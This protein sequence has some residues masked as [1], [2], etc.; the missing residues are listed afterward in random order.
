MTVGLHIVLAMIRGALSGNQGGVFRRGVPV[1]KDQLTST[2]TTG[3]NVATKETVSQITSRLDTAQREHTLQR[4]VV[5]TPVEG[6]VGNIVT[7]PPTAK[8][9]KLTLPK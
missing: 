1:A 2:Y 5:T 6:P 3:T 9:G 4:K 8:R 7:G